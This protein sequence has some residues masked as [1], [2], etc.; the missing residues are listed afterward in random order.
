[1]EAVGSDL[2]LSPHTVAL[3][4]AL[5]ASLLA[6]SRGEPPI[7]DLATTTS[8]QN[9][10]LLEDLLPHF[11]GARVRVHAAGSGRSLDML[12]DGIVDAVISHAPE[13]EADYL[14]THPDW[15]YRKI[16]FN[17]FV[18]VGPKSDA[19]RVRDA[20]H[21]LDALRRIADAPVTFISRGDGSGTHERERALWTA[22]GAMP[23]PERYLVSGRSMAITLRHAD[24][25]QGYTL[26]DQATFW[27]FEQDL[28]LTVLLD[29]DPLLLNTYAVVHPG[30]NETARLFAD[31]LSRGDGRER[32]GAYRVQGRLAFALW[33]TGCADA[34]PK[35]L[36]CLDAAGNR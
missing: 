12:H 2:T 34:E 16:A 10:G 11:A 26:S 3:V 30:G 28:D 25:R 33:P 29:E 22:A 20:S 21:A 7:L 15:S 17:R 24:E 14:V 35:A 9:S 4:C 36:P 19:A 6:C 27:Q 18:I 13:A 32:I 1:M 23:P 8:V 5:A 31:W